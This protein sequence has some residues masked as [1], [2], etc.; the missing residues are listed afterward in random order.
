MAGSF[1][2]SSRAGIDN[3]GD[4]TNSRAA[5]WKKGHIIQNSDDE[6]RTGNL[7]LGDRERS[8]LSAENFRPWGQRMFPEMHIKARAYE[9]TGEKPDWEKDQDGDKE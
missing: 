8:A 4:G 2:K 6:L 1:D 9:A 3:E 7:G 5:W